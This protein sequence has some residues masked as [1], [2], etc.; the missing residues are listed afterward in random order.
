[1]SSTKNPLHRAFKI[2]VAAHGRVE[3]VEPIDNVNL[4]VINLGLS[5]TGTTSVSAALEILGFAPCHQGVDTFRNPVLREGWISLL[6]DISSG[7]TQGS[8]ACPRIHHLMRGYRS[9]CDHPINMLPREVFA[10][11]LNAKYILATRVGGAA[12]WWKSFDGTVGVH[13][14]NDWGNRVFLFLLMPVGFLRRMTVQI[15]ENRKLCMS[16]F[17][18]VEAGLHD[19]HNALVRKVIPDGQLLEYNVQQGWGPLCEFLEVPVPD[20][21]FPMVNEADSMKTIYFGMQAFGAAAWLMYVGLVGGGVFIALKPEAR[22][23]LWIGVMSWT[24]RAGSS[25][26][27]VFS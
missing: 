14:R 25:L 3:N 7:R 24:V 16:M 19:K 13:F 26:K 10:T 20:V 8:E 5:R 9:S 22:G 6:K 12:A 4:Q 11:Y 27:G 2:D 23:W 21:P 1:M 17:G 15:E 18:S